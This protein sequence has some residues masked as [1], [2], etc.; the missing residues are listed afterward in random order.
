MTQATIR[1]LAVRP[2]SGVT[3]QTLA[4]VK[5][6]TGVT[7]AATL[8]M[9]GLIAFGTQTLQ[10]SALWLAGPWLLVPEL[11][12]IGIMLVSAIMALIGVPAVARQWKTGVVN[13]AASG[14]VQNWVMLAMFSA[15]TQIVWAMMISKVLNC[16]G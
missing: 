8:P 12:L 5:V 9:L 14:A 6:Q 16:Q 15:M 11:L 10:T 3:A 4:S 7:L 13:Q 1:P 2:Q